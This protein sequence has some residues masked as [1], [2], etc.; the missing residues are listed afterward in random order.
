M[1]VVGN[2]RADLGGIIRSGYNAG[3]LFTRFSYTLKSLELR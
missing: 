3:V 1:E 2:H